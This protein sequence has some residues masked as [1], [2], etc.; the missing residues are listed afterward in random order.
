MHRHPSARSVLCSPCAR[1]P[2]SG[3][4]YSFVLAAL[5]F[6]PTLVSVAGEVDSRNALIATGG[7]AAPRVSECR[8][9]IDEAIELCSFLVWRLSYLQIL[10]PPER[11]LLCES[12]RRR[13]I[14][15]DEVRFWWSG[16]LLA[17][18]VEKVLSGLRT[19]FFS[20]AGAPHARRREG[21]HRFAQEQSRIFVPALQ[22]LTA[23][24]KVRNCPSRDFRSCSIFDFFNS[25]GTNAKC[26]PAL[27]LSAYWV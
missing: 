21:P 5:G 10:L 4:V 2:S 18:T 14:V 19:K 15:S 26:H 12:T 7:D 6:A 22:R 13:G 24:E 16:P 27:K 1:P 25:I 17:D 8:P 23:T 11:T 3:A 9:E 20:P